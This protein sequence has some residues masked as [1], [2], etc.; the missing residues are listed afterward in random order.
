M[1]ALSRSVIMHNALMDFTFTDYQILGID[2]SSVFNAVG[3]DQL[4]K[5]KQTSNRCH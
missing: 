4:K 2:F 1:N 5:V 3:E